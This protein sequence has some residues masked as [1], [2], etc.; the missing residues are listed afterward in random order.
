[1]S[2]FSKDEVSKLNQAVRENA[3]KRSN[4]DQRDQIPYGVQRVVIASVEAKPNSGKQKDIHQLAFE[5]KAFPEKEK[6]RP[7]L[8]FFTLSKDAGASYSD[9]AIEVHRNKLIEW[10]QKA[11]GYE[12]QAAET[13]ADLKNQLSRFVDK[14]F[15]VA[16]RHKKELF[17][18]SNGKTHLVFRPE[19]W[20]YG[21]DTEALTMK[22][23]Q[24]II[25]LEPADAQR[26][27]DAEHANSPMGGGA[28]P[29][30]PTAIESPG[31]TPPWES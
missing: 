8:S 19:P 25:E 26:W 20:Y 3:E 6:Y 30:E 4:F 17:V 29:N 10:F 28:L 27:R 12:M 15:K 1:M 31:D 14:P 9:R 18:D 2:I 22:M 24:A 7:M 5:L 16:I 11:F 13:I 21:T 23:T